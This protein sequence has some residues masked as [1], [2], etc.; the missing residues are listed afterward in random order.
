MLTISRPRDRSA[1]WPIC[2]LRLDRSATWPICWLRLDQYADYLSTKGQISDLTN[3]LTT[4]WQISDLCQKLRTPVCKIAD[5]RP[6]EWTVV[7]VIYY[8]QSCDHASS[9]WNKLSQGFNTMTRVATTP[10]PSEIKR[11]KTFILCRETHHPCDI[12]EHKKYQYCDNHRSTPTCSRIDT[13]VGWYCR[14]SYR[15]CHVLSERT[16]HTLVD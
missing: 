3:M 11:R 16:R 5:H 6:V 14:F 4:T 12:Y 7:R 15:S 10:R 2:W 8:D 9:E 13:S 1:T